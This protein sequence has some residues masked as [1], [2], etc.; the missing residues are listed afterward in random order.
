MI[1]QDDA[2]VIVYVDYEH[3]DITK[4][5]TTSYKRTHDWTL[6][7]YVDPD[8]LYLYIN[9]DIKDGDGV[10]SDGRVTWRVTVTYKGCTDSDYLIEGTITIEN[11]GTLD[12]GIS[13]ITDS[14]TGATIYDCYV[15]TTEITSFPYTLTSGATMTC[16]Y[17]IDPAT[18][19]ERSNQVTV[20]TSDSRNYYSNV[21]SIVWGDP[22][23]EIDE[24]V[25]VDDSPDSRLGLDLSS[26]LPAT[27]YA[28][29]F[30]VDEE[31]FYE[32]YKDF[33]WD[34][35]G[36]NNC[37]DYTYINTAT[38]KGDTIDD[39]ASA[40]LIVHVQ[41]YDEE[42]AYAKASSD[43]NCFYPTF[44]NWGWS[45]QIE[46]DDIEDGDEIEW[47]LWAG[48]AQCDTDNGELVGTVTVS[49]T[50]SS[51]WVSV[52]VSYSI[53]SGYTLDSTHVY[54]GTTMYPQKNG[55]DTISPGQYSN[56][57]PFDDDFYII[58]H[59][60]VKQPDPDFGP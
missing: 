29:N 55:E 31:A 17:K 15:G 30:D 22:D 16:K 48:A 36:E 10:T 39:D 13:S 34:D 54:A 37:G 38:L 11:D 18:G 41:C 59:A 33:D 2:T 20:T 28:T 40:T 4:T 32:Y 6:T 50:V 24:A 25:T 26:I 9:G 27:L 51:G 21:A 12:V 60:V 3:L 1:D 57:G 7:K 23:P 43:Y 44:S 56:E 47:D 49:F 8:E 14:I 53:I 58:A 5:V 46:Y 19:D 45:N 42:T 35:Y 52:S